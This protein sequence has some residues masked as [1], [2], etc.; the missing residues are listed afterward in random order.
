MGRW[1]SH[2]LRPGLGGAQPRFVRRLRVRA[3]RPG[4][5]AQYLHGVA[6]LAG[7]PEEARGAPRERAG[8]RDEP[9]QGGG[10]TFT[11]SS[12]SAGSLRFDLR[13]ARDL[14]VLREVGL[15]YLEQLLGRRSDR[16]ETNRI[17]SFLDD[18]RV[19]DDAV[20]LAAQP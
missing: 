1:G 13:L 15:H 8:F 16:F 7:K 10:V 20:D 5:A 4:S 11:R 17:Q 3:H 12:P 18:L 19:A 14:R 2:A 6:A 9:R